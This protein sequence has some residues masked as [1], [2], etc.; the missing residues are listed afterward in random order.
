MDLSLWVFMTPLNFH[1]AS[2]SVMGVTT[3]NSQGEVP[4][5]LVGITRI[6]G[7]LGKSNRWL[8]LDC[9]GGGRNRLGLRSNHLGYFV[10]SRIFGAKAGIDL[11]FFRECCFRGVGLVQSPD[12]ELA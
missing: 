8:S 11:G 3:R 9:E 7:D 12:M 10:V 4:D 6:L 5:R 2:S 1:T